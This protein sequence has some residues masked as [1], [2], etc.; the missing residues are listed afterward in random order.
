MKNNTKKRALPK[1]LGKNFKRLLGYF[2]NNKIMLI[3]IGICTVVSAICSVYAVSLVQPI[4]DDYIIPYIGVVGADLLGFVHMIIL[5]AVIYIISAITSFLSA[6][7]LVNLSTKIMKNIR[8][9]MFEK[10]QKLPLNYFDTNAHGDIMSKYTVD[11]DALRQMISQSLPQ[12]VSSLLSIILALTFMFISSIT[13][14]LVAIA[15]F[16]GII[17]VVFMITKRSAKYFIK[18]HQNI[19]ALNGYVEEMI[20]GQRVIKV[21]NHEEE[22]KAKFDEY[23]EKVFDSTVKANTYSIMLYPIMRHGGFIQYSI[24]AILGGLLAINGHFELGAVVSFMLLVNM[25]LHPIIRISQEI[26]SVLTALAG[27][28]RIFD[29]IDQKEEINNGKVTRVFAE[30][31]NAG[32]L[33][34]SRHQTA[35]CAWKVPQEDGSYKLVELRGHVEFSHVDFGYNKDKLILKNISLYAKPSHKIAFVGSTGAGKTTITNLINRFYDIQSGAITF[36]GINVNDIDKNHLRKTISVVL[37]DTHLFNG[38]IKDNIRYARMDATE[39]EVIAS[40]VAANA[41]SFIINLPD[42]YDTVI[43]GDG[44]SLSQGQRQLLSIARAM[45]ANAQV[46]ILDEAT[47]SIDTRTEKLIE[48]GMS[49]LMEGKTVFVIAH[50]LSTVRHSNAIMLLENGEIIERGTHDDLIT[51]KGRYY[52]LNIGLAELM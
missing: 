21:F 13:L 8:M 33:V 23:N 6:R 37:Q 35:L 52:N 29:L 30:F 10:M 11:V 3:I 15:T 17:F 45:L 39:E 14:S 9:E 32:N 44:A 4:I 20:E 16:L 41:H 51:A 42:G 5:V 27:A 28:E 24:I 49:K 25:L 46:L 48:S 36:D 12:A 34:E 7:L 18:Q 38:T 43:T 47:S 50:R 2:K 26:N 22:S 19:G 1:N 40:A 31:D